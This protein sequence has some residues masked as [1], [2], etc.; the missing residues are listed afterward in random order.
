MGIHL[1]LRELLSEFEEGQ[2]DIIFPTMCVE[3]MG[4]L[5]HPL[6]YSGMGFV[7]QDRD[8]KLEFRLFCNKSEGEPNTPSPFFP[9]GEFCPGELLGHHHYYRLSATDQHGREWKSERFQIDRLSAVGPVISGTLFEMI[10]LSAGELGIFFHL[11]IRSE[12]E[13]PAGHYTVTKT[14]VGEDPIDTRMSLNIAQC[15]FGST[16]L[17][18]SSEKG[19]LQVRAD[20]QVDL[21]RDFETRLIEAMQFILGQ[22][23]WWTVMVKGDLGKGLLCLRSELDG[24]DP[25]MHPPINLSSE[26]RFTSASWCLAAKYFEYISATH[27]GE[28]LH[29]I[30]AWLRMVRES[31]SGSVFASGL[32]IG[33]AVEG[34]LKSQFASHHTNSP[35]D[36][37]NMTD[38]MAWAFEWMSVWCGDARVKDRI[39]KFIHSMNRDKSRAKDKLHALRESGVLQ[40]SDIKAWDKLRNTAAHANPLDDERLQE[41]T[42]LCG[43]GLTLLYRLIFAAIG[44]KGAYTDYSTRGWP[45]LDNSNH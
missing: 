12:I 33:I 16:S 5:D 11:S 20:E 37:A 32:A 45:T 25:K 6:R 31:H 9:E 43:A 8:R 14:F 4:R 21:A 13:I 3:Q 19:W 40:Q 39:C 27:A 38:A 7:R 29:P 42:D 34:I 2:L 1:L 15:K 41:W 22:R 24:A 36:D 35:E 30:S 28:R 17:R 26:H 10:C 23:I 18:I 44:Y